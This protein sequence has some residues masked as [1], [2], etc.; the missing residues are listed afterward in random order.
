MERSCLETERRESQVRS[1]HNVS[2]LKIVYGFNGK[3]V[4]GVNFVYG[5][6][7]KYVYIF[8]SI[9]EIFIGESERSDRPNWVCHDWTRAH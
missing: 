4:Y 7:G 5:F 3:I 2:E 6:S 8:S 1:Q 9:F